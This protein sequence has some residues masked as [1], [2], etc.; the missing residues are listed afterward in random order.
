MWKRGKEGNGMPEIGYSAKRCLVQCRLLLKWL[1]GN[2]LALF[3]FLLNTTRPIVATTIVVM[4]VP[5]EHNVLV[6]PF[7]VDGVP[8]TGKSMVSNGMHAHPISWL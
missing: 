3:Y 6:L 4:L 2:R 7:M 1:M 5:Y 8:N